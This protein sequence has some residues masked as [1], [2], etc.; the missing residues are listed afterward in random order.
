MATRHRDA[1]LINGGASNPI[2]IANAIAAA[3][4][5]AADTP[6]C[7]YTNDPAI[8]LMVHQLAHVVGVSEIIDLTEY[9]A[10]IKACEAQE[11]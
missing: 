7:S 8:R 6:G 1:L 10:A 5:E 2:A 9:R 11:A 3:C 4:R